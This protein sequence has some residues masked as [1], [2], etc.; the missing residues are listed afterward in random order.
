M[1]SFLR[2]KQTGMQN[3]LS[4]NILPGSFAPDDRS[5]Y[6]INS[7]ISCM[8]FEP[9]QSL[10]AVGTNESK[11]GSGRVYVFGQSRV[12]KLLIPPR[13][14]SFANLQ[15]CANRLVSLDT[16]NELIVWDLD[17]GKRI[18]GFHAPGVVVTMVTDPTLDWCFL[19]IQ[20][21]DIYAYD[22][23]RQR[24][25]AFRLSSFWGQRDPSAKAVA[26]ISMQLHPRDIGKLLIAYSHGVV[27]Y[28]FKQ[29]QPTQFF[30]Y[31]VPPGAPGGGGHAVDSLRKPR[32]T[33][34]VWHPTGTFIVTAH[35][36]GSLVFWD[37]KEARVVMA[38]TLYDTNVDQPG[39]HTESSS[40]KHPYL[41]LSWCCKTNP[42]DSGLL[43]AG[44]QA[45]NTPA[46][47][48]T[49]IELGVTPNYATSSWQVLADYCKGKRQSILET[50]PG[51]EVTNYFLVPRASPHFA[52][53][54]DPI[55]VLILL[56]SGELITLS[57][58]SGYPI[59]P[60]NQLH[61][62]LSFVHPFATKFAVTIMDR[63]R[64][65]SMVESR[66]QGESVLKGGAEAPRPRRRFEGRTVIQV[67]HADSTVRIWDVGHG[68]EIENPLQLQ[69]DV[70]R[71]L[72]RTDDV[73]ITTMSMAPTTG[74]FV[75]GTSGGE[76]VIYRWGV[77]KFFGEKPNPR[78]DPNPGGLTDISRRAE[79]SL[80]SGLQPFS[81]YEMMQGPITVVKASDVGFMAVGSEGGFLSVIDMRGPSVM[82]QASMLDFAKKEKR[83]SFL[84]GHS[85]ATEKEWPVAIEFGV[86]TLDEDKYSSICCFVGTNKGKVITFKLLPSAAGYTAQVAGVASLSDK[87]VAICPILAETG[88]PAYATGSA[89]AGLREGQD[90]NG[91]LVVV[92]HTEVRIF[93]PATAKG[94]SK[95]FDDILCDAACVTEFPLSGMALVGVFGDR[96]ARAFSLPGLKELGSAPLP[97]MDGSRAAGGTVVTDDG[98]L[99]CWTG[100]S[101]I[102][103]LDVWGTGQ[104]LEN[105]PDTLINPNLTIPP[106]RP[107]ISNMQWISGTQHVTPADLDLLIGGPD[108]PPSKRAAAVAAGSATATANMERELSAGRSGSGQEQEGWGDYLTRQ[109]NERTEKL[110]LMNDSMDSAAESSQRWA[111]STSK[112]VQQQKRKMLFGSI[113]GKFL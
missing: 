6:G 78:L 51:A 32:V 103:V 87:V 63:P 80:K 88:K 99:F 34:A 19:G 97:M 24:L 14:S 25:S 58:P 57:F 47:G 49:F 38:R 46:H 17:T 48:L 92:T 98:D 73:E 12:H 13:T 26:L 5:R 76:V 20:N 21:G 67:A 85:S 81:L 4:A 60:T 22:L 18:T 79:P 109:L 33:Q 9:V 39:T 90:V 112:F 84:K 37:A 71:S 107:T 62:S 2:G 55:A 111:D 82:Y 45:L 3:D 54:Q 40:P 31:H 91:L 15:F 56:S 27:V 16:K 74:E 94:A 59:S 102:A 23:D 72:D 104:Q 68:D 83:S 52:G 44:G 50:P 28:S 53:A 75:V 64:W 36:D 43:I 30:E 93:K 61:P 86:M 8:A 110:N 7:Q 10:L 35:D 1:A 101:E 70:A 96:V 77:N 69:V 29:N 65:L 106:P 100:P 41:K 89:V 105:T 11:F 113:T 108:R 42:E 66:N 95:T